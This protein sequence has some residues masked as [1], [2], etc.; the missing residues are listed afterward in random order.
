MLTKHREFLYAISSADEAIYN[1]VLPAKSPLLDA[2][3]EIDWDE[4]EA[5]I[6]GCYSPDKGQPAYPPLRLLKIELLSF[7][8]GLSDRQVIERVRTD[9]LCRYFLQIGICAPLPDASILSRFRSRVG[10]ENFR[11]IFDTLVGQARKRGLVKDRL[12]LTDSTHVIAAIAVPRALE[13]VAQLRDKMIQTIEGLSASDAEGFRVKMSS[14]RAQEEESTA[15]A[16]RLQS[17]V[18]IVAS[19]LDWLDDYLKNNPSNQ[20]PKVIAVRDLASKILG[21]QLDPKK[22]DRTL[23]LV[24]PDARRGFHGDYY[25]GYSMS[26]LVDAD[27]GICTCIDVLP[28]NADEVRN[29]VDMVKS[30]E[31]THGNDIETLSIDGIGF[32]GPTLRELEDP[33]GL[34]ID[35]IT[36]PRDFSATPGFDSSK[37]ETVND[38]ERLRC[39]AGHLSQK[40]ESVGDKDHI[41][42]YQFAPSHCRG[43]QLRAQCHPTMT[44]T[45]RKGRKVRVNQYLPEFEKARQKSKTEHYARVRSEHPM[46]ERKLNQMAN[47]LR[48]RRSRYWGLAKNKIQASI[49]GFVMNLK[50]ILPQLKKASQL[51]AA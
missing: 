5:L 3:D 46:V 35:V 32:H 45:S 7:M 9:L 38:G 50:A 39:P 40:A 36:P 44:D 42:T 49:T 8:Y 30:E 37:F 11:K 33:Q 25:D 23:S 17:R 21:E 15:P 24:D 20:D 18:A 28:A 13:L 26:I 2:L 22:N 43:C 29:A 47:H 19:M 4:F 12:R 41:Q 51:Q 27:S 14:I 48:G 10:E 16:V 6:D 31:A 34:N 1:R